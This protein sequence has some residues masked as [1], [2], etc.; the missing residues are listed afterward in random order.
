MWEIAG[1]G[2]VLKVAHADHELARAR[3]RREAEALAAIGPPAVPRL[4]AS[5]VLDDGRA[6]IAM[7]RVAGENLAD[8][9]AAGTLRVDQAV[10]IGEAILAALARVHAGSFVHR[11]LK[12][13]NLVR[14]PAGIVILDLG[15]ARR[16][17]DDTEDPTRAGVQVGSLEYMPPEQLLDAASAGVRADLYAFGCVLYELCAGR[18]PFVGDARA[19]ERAHAA[20]RPPPLAALA[21]VP[22]PL[23]ALVHDCL[24]KLPERR[25]GSADELRAR[26]AALRDAT[27]SLQRAQHTM[28]VLREGK[29]PVV[30]VWAELP[31]VDRTLLGMLSARKLTVISQRGRRVLAAS[32]GADHA[33]PAGAALA[34]ARDL[35]TAGARV[36]LHLDALAVQASATGTIVGGPAVDDPQSWLPPAPWTGIAITRALGTVLQVPMRALDQAGFVTLGERS[37]AAELFGRDALVA[38][39][40]SEAA[41]ALAGQGPGLA[42]LVGDPGIG[43]T[44]IAT[45]LIPQ[46][47]ELGARVHAG[48]VPPPGSGK[49]SSTALA[50]LVAGLREAP[51]VRAI[52]DALRAAARA[53]PAAVIVDNV[54]LAD[55]ELLD[56]LEY[57]TLGGEALPL[58]VLAIGTPRLEERRPS[59][60]A[61]AE[62]RRREVVPPLSEDASVALAAALLRPAE[63]PPL[64]ALRQLAGIAHGNPM[65]LATLARELHDRGAIR[66]RP[67]GEYFLDTTTLD[68]LPTLALGPWLAARVLAQLAPELAA[69]ARLCAALG[70]DLARDEIAAVVERVE[71]RGGATTTIDVDVGL[72]ELVQARVL[73]HASATWSFRQALVREG[74]YATTDEQER[75]A[76]HAAALDYWRGRPA[77]DA[78]RL[79]RHAEAVGERGVAAQAFA[80]LGTRAQAEH[81]ELDADQA[82]E[83]AL[84]NLDPGDPRRPEALLGRARARY[85]MQRRIEAVADVERVLELATASGD[86]A[87][88]VEALLEL[89]TIHD[90]TGS[91]EQSRVAA[92]RARDRG[93][94]LEVPVLR[95]GIELAQ[96]RSLYRAQQFDEATP[97]LYAV[98]EAARAAG[99][100]EHETIARLLLGL[101]LVDTGALDAAEH[102]FELLLA[103]CSRTGD[104]FHLAGVYINRARLW[105]VRGQFE[106]GA[107]DMREVIQLAREGGQPQLERVATYNAAQDLLWQGELDEALRLARRSLALQLGQGEGSAAVDRVLVARVLAARQ[108][109]VA[110]ADVLDAIARDDQPTDEL[111]AEMNNATAALLDVLRAVAGQGTSWEAAL[112]AAGALPTMMQIEVGLLAAAEGQLREPLRG[113]V[114][115]LA[116]A[117]P[118]FARRLPELLG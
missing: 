104:R 93:T 40:A 62:R 117:D 63:Y 107:A 109:R 27:P 2:G 106:R 46:L 87:L 50:Q 4:H 10:A 37:Q 23:E 115:A 84:R 30:L 34:A 33:D 5:G 79:A 97:A 75:V 89:A 54:H 25:P 48:E 118:A 16:I 98:A 15:L 102:E 82:W 65:H 67:N 60:G 91:F 24:A 113:Q 64:R 39:L 61:R 90:W 53:Q 8:T 14:T 17:P 112:A 43:K 116:Q 41:A 6:W 88:E 21:P 13:D 78:A 31:R 28:S 51:G 7:D 3:M 101:V 22:P 32:L 86:R 76:L 66:R 11:D 44:A 105:S 77:P 108:D 29:Q 74:I 26:L 110:L 92:E 57:A 83:G 47:R 9:I 94:G 38:D 59:F 111:D 80:V 55:A 45:A 81:H 58:W 35:A 68:S 42:L 99:T 96:A 12:P 19:L 85:R 1:G 103:L 52:G 71:R 18:P 56:A 49:P 72:A 100:A 70:D 95:V 73:E 114:V 36:A 20:L 69:L